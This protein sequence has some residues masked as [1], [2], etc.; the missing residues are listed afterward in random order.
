MILSLENLNVSL[1]ML[2]SHLPVLLYSHKVDQGCS[3]RHESDINDYG[4]FR[5]VEE[6]EDI[7]NCLQ[8][9]VDILEEL[10]VSYR[11]LL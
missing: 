5:N 11:A 3:H 4:E 7:D 10:K 1:E 9:P 8:D 6:N 2:L